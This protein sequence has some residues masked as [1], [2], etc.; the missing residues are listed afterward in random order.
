M[1]K[2]DNAILSSSGNFTKRID[3]KKKLKVQV[4]QKSQFFCD[5]NMEELMKI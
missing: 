4:E 5:I 1:K 2:Y 3:I